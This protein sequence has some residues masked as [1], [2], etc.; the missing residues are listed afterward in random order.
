MRELSYFTPTPVASAGVPDLQAEH[1]ALETMTS[2]DWGWLGWVKSL[3]F[4]L[5]LGVTTVG[6]LFLALGIVSPVEQALEA[7][8]ER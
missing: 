2:V 7:D 4:L 8:S 3:I 6:V 1:N 5:L